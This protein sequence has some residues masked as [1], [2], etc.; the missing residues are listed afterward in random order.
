MCL[1]IYIFLDRVESKGGR[2]SPVAQV[3]Q[4]VSLTLSL[5]TLSF[6]CSGLYALGGAVAICDVV[7]CDAFE[8][9]SW[10]H[11]NT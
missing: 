10:R 2:F 3:T 8:G 11:T 4:T 1:F 7:L 6:P 9:L 5:L